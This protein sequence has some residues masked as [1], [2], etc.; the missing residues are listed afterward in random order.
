MA[1]I[2]LFIMTMIALL[3][4]KKMVV[5]TFGG[6]FLFY[7]AVSLVS[8]DGAVSDTPTS[9]YRSDERYTILSEYEYDLTTTE[10][11][12]GYTTYE[13]ILRNEEFYTG[14]TIIMTAHVKNYYKYDA[15]LYGLNVCVN[16]NCDESFHILYDGQPRILADDTI[17]AEGIFTGVAEIESFFGVR[18]TPVLDANFVVLIPILINYNFEVNSEMIIS[19]TPAEVKIRRR[20]HGA[21][22]TPR[23]AADRFDACFRAA[24]R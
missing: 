8:D 12:E 18:Y 15:S 9:N 20:Y 7:I 16:Y 19:S 21:R 22:N 11:L 17:L 3:C 13:K 6:I 24:A 4:M 1:M 10:S 14:K 5:I 2:V 23:R